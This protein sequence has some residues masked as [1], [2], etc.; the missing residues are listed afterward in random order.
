MASD[1][2]PFVFSG[3][4]ELNGIEQGG[5]CADELDALLEGLDGEMFGEF[6]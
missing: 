4:E 1:L 3:K 6:E 2:R 5:I